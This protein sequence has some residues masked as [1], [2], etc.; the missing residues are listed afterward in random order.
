[1]NE[2][3]VVGSETEWSGTPEHYEVINNLN[4]AALKAI[5]ES[6]EKTESRFVSTATYAARYETEPVCA[7]RLPDDPQIL[8]SIHCYYGTA[9]RSEFLDCENKLTLREKYEMYEIFRN[10]Y[11]III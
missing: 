8:V 5:R 1:M 9:H 3:R 4:L 2:P 7:L 11:K 10:I 6:G